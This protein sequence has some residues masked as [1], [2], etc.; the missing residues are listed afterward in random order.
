M[1]ASSTTT[2]RPTSAAATSHP[3][4][5]PVEPTSP[6]Y[7]RPSREGAMRRTWVVVAVV[8]LVGVAATPAS[9]GEHIDVQ[10][11]VFQDHRLK[12]KVLQC[13][14]G[15]DWSAVIDVSVF[16]PD[17]PHRVLRSVR[18]RP[19]NDT[20]LDIFKFHITADDFPRGLYKARAVCTH[21]FEDGPQTFFDENEGFRVLEP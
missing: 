5:D 7:V 2:R 20:G 21:D 12:V 9:A 16:D 17:R 1:R 11:T 19:A 3:K 6:V 18:D 8:L 14:S 13:V 15:A 10:N 4:D